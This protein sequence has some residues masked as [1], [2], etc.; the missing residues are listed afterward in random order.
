MA[1]MGRNAAPTV[2]GLA[3]SC[4]GFA[5][6]AVSTQPTMLIAAMGRSYRGML[7]RRSGP[8]P[9]WVGTRQQ[10]CQAWILHVWASMMA[11]SHPNLRNYRIALLHRLAAPVQQGQIGRLVYCGEALDGEAFGQ[12]GIGGQAVA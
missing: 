7:S 4:L 6:R 9:R 2:P 12:L 10:R 1:A 5:D 8:W 11:L 3:P